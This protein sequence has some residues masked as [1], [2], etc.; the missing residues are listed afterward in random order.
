MDQQRNEYNI[1][2]QDLAYEHNKLKLTSAQ[3]GKMLEDIR[4]YISTHFTHGEMRHTPALISLMEHVISSIDDAKCSM[5]D[6][7]TMFYDLHQPD[8]PDQSE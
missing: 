8:K 5:R 4:Y 2:R 3:L 7:T 6:V 1:L